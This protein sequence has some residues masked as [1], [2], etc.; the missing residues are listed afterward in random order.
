LDGLTATRQIKARWPEIRV[1]AH[2]L[3]EELRAEAIAAG[4]DC[5]IPKG[6]PVQELLE[7]LGEPTSAPWASADSRC[8]SG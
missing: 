3:A 5:F 2:S 7:A 4:A 8:P 1:V 6:A